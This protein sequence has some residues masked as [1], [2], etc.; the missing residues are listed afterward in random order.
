[1]REKLKFSPWCTRNKGQKKPED[2]QL[3]WGEMGKGTLETSLIHTME[4]VWVLFLSFFKSFWG[5][6]F[7]NIVTVCR[8]WSMTIF[9]FYFFSL[10]YD[11]ESRWSEIGY[12]LRQNEEKM[13][14]EEGCW[15]RR[16]DVFIQKYRKISMQRGK[17]SWLSRCWIN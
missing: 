17:K 7:K 3:R 2:W 10:R 8:S 1:M 11:L 5:P 14:K 15:I 6:R 4:W 16:G 12:N 13:E 9:N